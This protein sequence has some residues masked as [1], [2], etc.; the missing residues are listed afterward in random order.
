[1]TKDPNIWILINN[2][3]VTTPLTSNILAG[4]TRKKILEIA[5]NLKIK[6]IEK[7]FK[8]KDLY[9]ADAT[10]ITN[11]SSIIQEANRLG[12]KKLNIDKSGILMKLK[13]KMIYIIQN[14]K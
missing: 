5:T 12:N 13:D 6:T 10:F 4:V 7:K 9:N 11:S 2:N 14:D 1:M 8:I 3:L